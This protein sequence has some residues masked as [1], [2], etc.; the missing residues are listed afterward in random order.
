MPCLLTR[1]G[2]PLCMPPALG[3]S[4][5]QPHVLRPPSPRCQGL[6]RAGT[7]PRDT[8]STLNT[9]RRVITVRVTRPP[10]LMPLNALSE[11]NSTARVPIL[12]STD[13]G[14]T[15][16]KP[17]KNAAVGGSPSPQ[18]GLRMGSGCT[19]HRKSLS[20]CHQRGVS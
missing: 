10:A 3:A 4:S 6:E 16:G 17:D 13:S 20:R 7:V 8:A 14:D 18:E 1:A 12:E 9:W 5:L 15:P 2:S 11:E 19:T